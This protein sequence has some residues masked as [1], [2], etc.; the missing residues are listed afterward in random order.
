LIDRM[1]RMR[2]VLE[3]KGLGVA[4]PAKGRP[5][6]RPNGLRD[7]VA[8]NAKIAKTEPFGYRFFNGS[9]HPSPRLWMAGGEPS[10][11]LR[12]AGLNGPEGNL[13]GNPG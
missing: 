12:R 5:P 11:L 4:K 13:F 1:N 2:R 6:W 9:H 10:T 7:K 8:K 3:S